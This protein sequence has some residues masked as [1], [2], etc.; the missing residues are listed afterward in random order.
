MNTNRNVVRGFA[1]AVAAVAA[2][3]AVPH[4]A[5][6]SCSPY[7]LIGSDWTSLGGASGPLGNC[8]DNEGTNG[9]G[10][11]EIEQFEGGWINWTG[12]DA[13]YDSVAYA[14]WGA[15]ATA[16]YD[17]Y[18]FL[19]IGQPINNE[20]YVPSYYGNFDVG[21][22]AYNTFDYVSSGALEYLVWNADPNHPCVESNA[23]CS[24]YGSIGVA[25]YAH[26]SAYEQ[27]PVLP[28]NNASPVTG[29]G[30]QEFLWNLD[31]GNPG[32]VGYI[33]W[34][35]S[36]NVSCAWYDDTVYWQENDGPCLPVGGS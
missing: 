34:N 4:V 10:S 33:T 28:I 31:A 19:S 3:L 22:A 1:S 13:P 17:D 16:W 20:S 18:S 23:V 12:Y 2:L 9:Y 14:V 6:A 30:Q 8:I 36:N 15:I 32:G 29:G 5:R 35:S 24:I 27:T 21:Y 26:V 25:W 11:G 7:G